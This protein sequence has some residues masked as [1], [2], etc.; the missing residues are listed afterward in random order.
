MAKNFYGN[1]RAKQTLTAAIQGGRL[2]HAYLIEG[3]DGIGKT[4]F[5][6]HFAS[7]VLCTGKDKPCGDCPACYKAERLIHPD[8]HLY[9][10]DNKKNSFHVKAVRDIKESV[11]TRP[12]DGDYKVYIL[13]RAENMTAEAQNALLKMLEEPPE[14]TV[15]FLTC[16]NRMKIPTTVLSRCVPIVLSTVTDEECQAA[17]VE[18]GVSQAAAKELAPR[19]HGNIGLALDAAND[20]AYQAEREQQLAVLN[21][22]IAGNEYAL[23]KALSAYE[24]K[25]QEL[26]ELLDRLS[27]TVRDAIVLKSGRTELIGAFPTEA[28]KLTHCLTLSQG[29]RLDSLFSQIKKQLDFNGNIPLTLLLLGSKIKDI[30][31]K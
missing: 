22:V 13:C 16:R 25:K 18:N 21:A 15:F 31:E 27:E 9:L 7:A 29:V 26:Y 17:L 3:E 2:C 12:N 20:A 4:A 6:L 14:D 28:E 8:L 1:T 5:A 23:L 24:G 30:T 10:S 19:F 11:Y